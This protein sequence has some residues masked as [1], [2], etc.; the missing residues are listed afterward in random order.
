[1]ASAFSHAIAALS[2]GTCFY[3]PQ[4]PKRVWIAGAVFAV[5]PDLDAIGFRFGI[6]YS[7]FASAYV[8]GSVALAVILLQGGLET[9]VSMLR[10]AFWPALALAV[11]G[12]AVTA[13]IVGAAV[14]AIAGVP[15]VMAMQTAR[16]LLVLALGPALARAS[17]RWVTRQGA[18][19][20]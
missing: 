14:A 17:V 10:I 5:I 15:F 19:S 12:V 8:I 1:M 7:D 4:T 11:V 16:F 3:R 13:C 6:H 20:A 9:H 2:L 18:E